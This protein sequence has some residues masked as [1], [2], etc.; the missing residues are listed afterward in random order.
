MDFNI[1]SDTIDELD[2][3]FLADLELVTSRDNVTIFPNR[4]AITIIDDDG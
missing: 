1:A 3:S 4:A 2:E